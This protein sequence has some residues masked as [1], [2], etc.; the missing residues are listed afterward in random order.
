M[1]TPIYSLLARMP[2][3]RMHKR[4]G[5]ATADRTGVYQPYISVPG[6]QPDSSFQN[7]ERKRR[8]Q[9]NPEEPCG[10]ERD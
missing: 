3:T 2:H 8:V 7:G 10:E 4:E 6:A 5:T 1:L 9:R